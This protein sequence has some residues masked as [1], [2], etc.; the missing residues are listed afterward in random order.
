MR[1]HI[2]W[3]SGFIKALYQG[4]HYRS[5]PGRSQVGCTV[6]LTRVCQE[7]QLPGPRSLGVHSQSEDEREEAGASTH[8]GV[9]CRAGA[10]QGRQKKAGKR[11]PPRLFLQ[12]CGRSHGQ[13][14]LSLVEFSRKFYLQFRCKT[15]GLTP[16][17]L[18][19]LAEW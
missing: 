6:T 14:M 16:I 18:H 13:K 5:S 2:F 12:G 8:D 15:S 19:R 17:F 3:N 11:H 10:S 1:K 9:R 4:N 7:H